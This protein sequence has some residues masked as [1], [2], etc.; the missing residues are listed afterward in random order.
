[1]SIEKQRLEHKINQIIGNDNGCSVHYQVTHT[2]RLDS[3]N[4]SKMVVCTYNPN[5]DTSFLL[6]EGEIEA[7]IAGN[8]KL[9]N[10][11]TLLQQLLDYV[12][13]EIPPKDLLHYKIRWTKKGKDSKMIDSFFSGRTAK[14]I[15]D[16]FFHDKNNHD[17]II[18]EMVLRPES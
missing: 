3:K 6:W 11:L 9:D 4:I 16:K 12:K 13:K 10:E 18:Y 8:D 2:K 1:M 5:H 7:K 14:E 17:Y 15:V